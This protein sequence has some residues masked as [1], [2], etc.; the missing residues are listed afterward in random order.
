MPQIAPPVP[1][2][3]SPA[4]AMV[5]PVAMGR[6]RIM[7]GICAEREMQNSLS[8]AE[9]LESVQAWDFRKTGCNWGYRQSVR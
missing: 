8:S 7:T 9:G 4:H 2:D 5:S 1:A 6:R 3:I